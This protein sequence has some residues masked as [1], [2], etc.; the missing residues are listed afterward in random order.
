MAYVCIVMYNSIQ[1]FFL[2]NPDM[3]L[4]YSLKGVPCIIIGISMVFV[5]T[6]CILKYS[7]TF[8]FR[9]LR[10]LKHNT[11]TKLFA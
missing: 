3:S 6:P 5:S 4:F 10:L 11:K 9:F 7:F 1:A 2:Y 8:N